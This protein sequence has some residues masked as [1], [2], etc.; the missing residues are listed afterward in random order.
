MATKIIPKKSSVLSKVPLSTDIEVGEIALN[1]ADQKIYTKTA[2]DDIIVIG[3]GKDIDASTLNSLSSGQFLRADVDDTAEGVITFEDDII[4]KSPD[5]TKSITFSMLDS[6]VLQLDN[7]LDMSNKNIQDVNHIAFNTTD[8]VSVPEGQIAWSSEDGTLNVGLKGS[9]VTLQL[10]QENVAYVL[11]NTAST[12]PNGTVVA[13]AGAQNG[14]IMVEPF[15]ADGTYLPWQIGG[16]TTEAIAS[17][18]FG[19]VTTF[20]YVRDINTSAYSVGTFL[21]ASADTAGAFTSVVP[22]SPNIKVIV[23]VVTEQDASTGSVLVRPTYTPIASDITYDNSISELLSTNVKAALDELQAS[24][25]SVDLLS[26]TVTVYAT[27]ASSDVTGYF[28][29][30]E[31]TSDADYD[32]P[33]VNVSTGAI[34]TTSQ[35]ISSLVSDPGLFVGDPGAITIP[36]IGNIRRTAGSGTA[37]F[38]FEVYKR[39]SIGNETLVATSSETSAV[40]SET[41]QQFNASALLSSGGAWTETDRIVLK[42]YANRGALGSDPTYDF[43]FGG[44]SPV[45]TNFP[46][47]VSVIPSDSA[48]EIL[49]AT[50]NFNGILSSTDSNVQEALET[51]D[52]HTHTTSDITEGFRLY[53][54]DTRANNAIDARVTKSFVDALNVDA[55]TLDGLDSTQFLRSDAADTKTSGDL[56]FS[57]NI[58]ATFGAGSDLQIY[59]DGSNSYIQDLGVGNLYVKSNVFRVY[60][61]A[62]DEISAN[63]VQNSAVTLYYDGAPKFATTDTG[64]DVTGDIEVNSLLNISAESGT[65]SS[66]TQ[67]QIA[68]FAAAS[69]SS[70]KF[71]I[72][73]SDSVYGEVHVTELLVVHDG[74]TASATEYGTIYTGATPLAAYDVDIDSGNV[75]ILATAASANSTTYKVTENLITA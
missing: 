7:S 38:Y 31:S 43:Q 69:Y 60:N 73:A 51:L 34:T 39:D 30:V 71:V 1:L 35:L 50:S 18:E 9:N 65:T 40:S 67:T 74:T 37:S 5:G 57:D 12:I 48:D 59:H 64:V 62:G 15:I 33:A 10:G 55:D 66:T 56:A 53:Y 6:D 72:Q 25:A 29:L 28:S 70:G 20:G 47:P 24:K 42:F 23:G 36:T 44:T 46:V 21:Y 27:T 54:T 16:V 45:R 49:V 14:R 4:F 2:S 22:E 68:S 3:I 32:S 19:Y 52:D 8:G 61:A 13:V 17:G 75:R 63:F 11:N 58:K 41:Y 26:S